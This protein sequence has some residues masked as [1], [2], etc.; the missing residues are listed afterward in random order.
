MVDGEHHGDG[1][2][3]TRRRRGRHAAPAVT[4]GLVAGRAWL[5]ERRPHVLILAVTVVVVAVLGGAFSARSFA[6]APQ[7]LDELASDSTTRP[8]STDSAGPTSYAPILPSP[9][10]PPSVSPAGPSAP[11]EDSAEQAADVPSGSEAEPTAEPAPIAQPEG[12]AAPGATNPP[13]ATS[14]PGATTPPD[15]AKAPADPKDQEDPESCVERRGF[16]ELL[17]LGP[18]CP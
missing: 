7:A 15:E 14:P 3:G 8:T 16:L 9:G 11:R 13:D 17:L 10:P 12:E 5:L 4:G 18:S 2:V 1:G 6:G